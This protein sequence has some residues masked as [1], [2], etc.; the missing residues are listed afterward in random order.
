MT[1]RQAA[2]LSLVLTLCSAGA[3]AAQQIPDPK[4]TP[5]PASEKQ[6]AAVR[7]GVALH[8]RGDFDGAIRR[9]E[10]VLAENPSNVL[11]LYEMSYAYTEKKDYRKALEVA[12]RG[13]QYHSEQ[14]DGF[15][16]LMGNNLDLLGE[17]TKAIEVYKKGLKL[18]PGAGALQFNLAVAYKNAGKLDDARKT[19]K[20]GLVANPQHASSHLLL[21][22]IFFNTG[23]K[24]PAFFA[25]AR[26]LTLE[27]SSQRSP[28][29]ARIVSEVLGSGAAPGKNPGEISITLDYN[30]KKD[31]GDFTT[32]DTIF[33]LSAAIAFR[34]AEKDKGKTEAQKV[35]A[36]MQTVL[37]VLG[38][39]AE[40][41]KQSTFT[42]QYYVPY[43]IEMKRKGHV[44]AFVYHAL[45][46]SGLPGAREWV[47]A[48]G[49]R[50][51]QFLIWSKGYHWPENVKT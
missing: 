42:F 30:P 18:F 14:L 20:D 19:L 27:P 26:F 28:L 50:V 47:G 5:E 36:Q 44:E 4:L 7:E 46:S 8:D 16:V 48:N 12:M 1:T 49:G 22:V 33:G 17:T 32:L 2:L 25:A 9:Y 24:A 43:F 29:A 3:A 11:A 35:V 45:Q 41:K 51:M 37:T 31:E 40:K 13:A 38:E 10:S 34:D 21:A 15:Y 6:T 23:Y 39:Q